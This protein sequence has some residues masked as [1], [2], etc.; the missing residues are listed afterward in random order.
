MTFPYALIV[1]R[2][3]EVE[4]SPRVVYLVELWKMVNYLRCWSNWLSLASILA[5]ND[6]LTNGEG[7]SHDSNKDACCEVSV[8]DE[9]SYYLCMYLA[10][11][12]G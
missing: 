6:H 11:V 12:V 5:R 9:V 3:R 1:G 4:V 10:Y 2:N 8:N 7:K